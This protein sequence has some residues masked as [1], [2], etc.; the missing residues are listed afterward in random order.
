MDLEEN[1]NRLMD[2]PEE[3]ESRLISRSTFA[4]ENS[5]ANIRENRS[6]MNRDSGQTSSKQNKLILSTADQ[7][8]TFDDKTSAESDGELLDGEEAVLCDIC[9]E[10]WPPSKFFGLSC[11]HNFCKACMRE[12]L[13]SNIMDGKIIKIPCM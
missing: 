7:D 5:Q 2:I 3:N 10:E 11:G 9:Y 6:T 4:Q 8:D 12:H 1:Q 13:K